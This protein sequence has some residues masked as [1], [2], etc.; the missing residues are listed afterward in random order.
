MLCGG[1]YLYKP[2]YEEIDAVNRRV[3]KELQRDSR[4]TTS[5][6]GHRVGMSSQL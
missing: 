1:R 4:L 5:E 2:R 6:L 3:L